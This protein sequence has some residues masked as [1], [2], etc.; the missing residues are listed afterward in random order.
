MIDS[1]MLQV[2]PLGLDG[3][4]MFIFIPDQMR[5][6]HINPIGRFTTGKEIIKVWYRKIQ[7]QGACRQRKSEY[8]TANRHHPKKRGNTKK[9]G[10]QEV[11]GTFEE[12]LTRH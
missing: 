4:A 7:R 10:T 2:N 9:K 5:F 8:G 12:K 3:K 6:I 1:F 11:L